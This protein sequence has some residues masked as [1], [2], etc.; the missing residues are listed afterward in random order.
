M[1]TRVSIRARDP[2]GQ[3][4]TPRPKA[5][6]SRALSAVDV[7]LGRIRKMTGIPVGGTVEH[8]QRC[9]GRDVDPGNGRLSPCQPEVPFHR[10]LDPERLLHEVRNEVTPLPEELLQVRAIADELQRGA[11]EPHRRLL[12]GRKQVG[13]N[14]DDV[15]DLGQLSV[16]ERRCRQRG[17]HVIAR[18]PAAVLDIAAE[19]VVEPLER[20]V[21][22]HVLRAADRVVARPACQS[23]PEFLVFVLWDPEEVGNDEQ[24]E[25]VGV[26]ADELALTT[27]DELVDLTVGEPPHEFL[28]LLQPLRCE[29]AHDQVPVVVVL[30]WVHR[31][32]L[33]TERQLVAV[34]LDQFAHV[35]ATFELNGKAGKRTRHRVAGRERVGVGIHG[36]SLV[37]PGDHVDA[38][39]GLAVHRALPSQPIKVRVGVADELVPAKEVDGVEAEWRRPW[40]LLL[41]SRRRRGVSR[42]GSR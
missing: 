28:V 23:V 21:R 4:W 7:E 22:Q 32:E 11:E 29:L 36:A 12:S 34:S 31:R 33:V 1:L 13:G 2:P 14:A 30:G 20:A 17:E 5:R 41:R 27:S 8:H 19:A 40:C 3:L 37:V 39:L 15:D 35:V 26:V 24:R 6:C 18:V 38:L 9:A 42:G 25:R 10:G 16:G